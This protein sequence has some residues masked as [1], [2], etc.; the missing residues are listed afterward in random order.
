[1]FFSWLLAGLRVKKKA[2]IQRCLYLYKRCFRRLGDAAQATIRCR[3]LA[4]K[5]PPFGLKHLRSVTY[6]GFSKIPCSR[7][8]RVAC[9]TLQCGCFPGESF[10]TRRSA[11]IPHMPGTITDASVPLCSRC[12]CALAFAPVS[13]QQTM[14]LILPA[15]VR[16]VVGIAARVPME[17]R[18]MSRRLSS[19][20]LTSEGGTLRRCAPSL[21]EPDQPKPSLVEPYQPYKISLTPWILTPWILIP[22]ILILW[23]LSP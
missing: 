12:R 18:L 13:P 15:G 9:V 4:V 11:C 6:K 21:V 14:S 22:W 20:S 1:M 23:I 5:P 19:S 7:C 8:A 17:M 16:P 2:L 3:I 10:I